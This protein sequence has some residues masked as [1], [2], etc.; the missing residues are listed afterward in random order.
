VGVLAYWAC[1][2]ESDRNFECVTLVGVLYCQV[3]FFTT[4]RSL[5][6]RSPTDCVCVCQTKKE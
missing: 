4:G 1:G 3:E 2:F 6:Q 5:V